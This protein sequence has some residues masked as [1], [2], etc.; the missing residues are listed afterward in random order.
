MPPS[1]AN[2]PYRIHFDKEC[3]RAAVLMCLRVK[4]VS[5]PVRL[6]PGMQS[7]GIFV[8]Q[9]AEISSWLVSRC[10]RQKHQYLNS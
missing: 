4:H 7:H 10:N 8:E 3:C 2:Q 6:L 9:I 1:V 5:N